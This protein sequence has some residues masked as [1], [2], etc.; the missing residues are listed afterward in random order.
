VPDIASSALEL[1]RSSTA[2]V[3]RALE[4]A[5][6]IARPGAGD[7]QYVR[8]LAAVLG[9]L[10]PLE[11]VLWSS[12]W[13]VG[14]LPADRSGKAAWIHADLTARGMTAGE[15]ALIPREHSLPPLG[16]LAERFGVAY[17][18][19][20]AQ[21]GGQVLRRR[22]GTRLAPLPTRWL[23]G[24]RDQVGAKWRALLDALGECLDD[25]AQAEAAAHAARATFEWVHAWFVRQEVA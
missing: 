11:T 23:D 21:L 10:E 5:L 9:W 20:G 15:I 18:V 14:V 1:I 3:H 19:E 13:P 7:H 2:E 12:P 22:L 16:S 24:Y 17:V 25:R 8:Y 4:D 6:F